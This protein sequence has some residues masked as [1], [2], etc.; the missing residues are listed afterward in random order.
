MARLPRA[1]LT[2]EDWFRKP[3]NSLHRGYR[4]VTHIVVI[5]FTLASGSSMPGA[6]YPPVMPRLA[7][8]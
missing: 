5:T 3:R 4:T 2:S 6:A 1:Q 8:P 7:T